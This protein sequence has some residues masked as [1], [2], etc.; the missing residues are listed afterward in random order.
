MMTAVTLPTYE[1]ISA[2]ASYLAN[3]LGGGVHLSLSQVML[4]LD[5]AYPGMTEEQFAQVRQVATIAVDEIRTSAMKAMW[6]DKE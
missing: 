5:S 2:K 1:Q 4:S 6:G 3:A